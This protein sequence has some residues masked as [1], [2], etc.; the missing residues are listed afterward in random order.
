G[1]IRY[2]LATGPEVELSAE[3]VFDRY[4]RL[5]G[6]D[7]VEAGMARRGML[8]DLRFLQAVEAGQPAFPDFA[9]ALRAHEVVEAC[10][11]SAAGGTELDVGLV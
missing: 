8:E 6:L 11:R 4:T 10:Y 7:D 9:V 5:A 2:A 1:P 3:E